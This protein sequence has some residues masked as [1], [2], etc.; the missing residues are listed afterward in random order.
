VASDLFD[1]LTRIPIVIY[2]GDNIPTKPDE[3]PG[4]DNWRVRLNMAQLWV[5]TI[6]RHGGQAQLVHLPEL[7]IRGNT[8]FP[9]SDLNNE[10]IAVLLQ[11]WLHDN[12]LD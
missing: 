10:Q 5:D 4:Q 1:K 11:Q 12:R 2:Y 9:F 3:N 6:N 8:H 7:G